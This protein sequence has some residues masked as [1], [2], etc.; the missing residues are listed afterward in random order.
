[1]KKYTQASFEETLQRLEKIGGNKSDT[2]I[3]NVVKSIE[4]SYENDREF[5]K[6]MA[7]WIG[8]FNKLI[9]WYSV[10]YKPLSLNGQRFFYAYLRKRFIKEFEFHLEKDEYKS[11]FLDFITH[12]KCLMITILRDIQNKTTK[13]NGRKQT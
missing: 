8:T 6:L 2:K 4:L 12:S 3:F 7:A 9:Y 13:N 11:E 1:M 10:F 5:Q